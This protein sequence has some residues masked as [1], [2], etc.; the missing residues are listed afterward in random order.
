VRRTGNLAGMREK[1]NVYKILA[2]KY[3]GKR[4]HEAPRNR[5]E[6]NTKWSLKKIGC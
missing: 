4:P 5:W 3:E 2:G 6:N 1:K